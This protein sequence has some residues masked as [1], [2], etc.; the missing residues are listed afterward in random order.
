MKAHPVINRFLHILIAVFV[1]V[2]Q[3]DVQPKMAFDTPPSTEISPPLPVI[4]ENNSQAVYLRTRIDN[5]NEF[6]KQCPNE[7]PAYQTIRNAFSIL[8]DDVP[9]GDV[10]CTN[11]FTTMPIN[12]FTNELISLQ[13]MRIA[14]YMDPGKPDYLPWTSMNLFSWMTSNISGVNLKTAPGQLYCCDLIG[15]KYYI[16]Q[17]IQSAEQREYKR[18]WTGLA[19]TLDYYAHEIRHAE[20]GGYWH[21]AGC[22]AFPNGPAGCDPSYDI[23]NLGSYGIQYWLNNAWYSGYLNIGESCSPEKAESDIQWFVGALNIYRDRFVTNIPS[24]VSMPDL[25]Y[26]GPCLP[27]YNQL[28]LSE[29]SINGPTTGEIDS[30]YTFTA[31]SN[32]ITATL[33]ITYVWQTTGQQSITHTNQ[34][35]DTV[36]FSWPQPGEKI[37]TV[38][39]NNIVSSV[40]ATHTTTISGITIPKFIYVPLLVISP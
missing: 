36:T 13:V 24:L 18:E 5:I 25:P 19:G 39:A 4:Y 30:F 1:L 34:L 12:E 28:G 38:T 7:D 21:V 17:S 15:G 2:M 37:I 27:K 29:T 9:V 33:P 6:I 23:N 40:V 14:Y 32:P 16:S 35:S 8:K 20:D 26:G 10:P 3:S 31:M 22:A 11:P